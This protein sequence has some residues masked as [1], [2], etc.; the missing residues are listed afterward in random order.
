MVQSAGNLFLF[1]LS[2]CIHVFNSFPAGHKKLKVRE[3]ADYNIYGNTGT[4]RVRVAT[5]HNHILYLYNNKK[6]YTTVSIIILSFLQN[7][8]STL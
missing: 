6:I 7:Y 2:P 3:D 1:L 8:T 4:T 5:S